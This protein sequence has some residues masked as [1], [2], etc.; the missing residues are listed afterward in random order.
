MDQSS[1]NFQG[2]ISTYVRLHI[3]EISLIGQLLV[4]SE[5][6]ASPVAMELGN[7]SHLKQAETRHIQR[8]V[9]WDSDSN[10][11]NLNQ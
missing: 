1:P 5:F 4:D 6:L 11:M 3:S 8:W 2:F 10:L 7:G 9:F